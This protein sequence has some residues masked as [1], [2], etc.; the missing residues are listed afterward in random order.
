VLF[1]LCEVGND[2]LRD[3]VML[4]LCCHLDFLSSTARTM[5]PC[6]MPC[7]PAIAS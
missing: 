3:A 4:G 1:P 5:A 7:L 6:P 2:L